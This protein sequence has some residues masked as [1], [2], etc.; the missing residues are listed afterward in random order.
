MLS[1]DGTHV[2]IV[3]SER[4]AG[5]KSTIV[6]NYVTD[7]GYTDNIQARSNVGDT[8]DRRLL[9][10]LNL[11]TGKTAWADGSFGG[12]A[13]E[14]EKPAAAVANDSERRG[15]RKAEREIRWSMPSVSDDGKFAVAVRAIG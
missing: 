8:Q 6:P 9:G 13:S 11:E 2:F 5:V 12:G 1:P 3:V 14:E 7:S 10:V 15:D 4:A